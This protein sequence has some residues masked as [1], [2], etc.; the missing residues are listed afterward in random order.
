MFSRCGN[1]NKKPGPLEAEVI[2]VLHFRGGSKCFRWIRRSSKA[3][4]WAVRDLSDSRQIRGSSGCLAEHQFKPDASTIGINDQADQT[5]PL[6]P[7]FQV[8][9][10]EN[11][12]ENTVHTGE[13]PFSC[14]QCSKSFAQS[15]GLQ[16]HLRIHSGEKPYSCSQCS[17]SFAQ[18]NHL[19]QHFR[20]HSG[21]K[22]YSCSQCSMSAADL[23]SWLY[24]LIHDEF[25]P[26]EETRL[27]LHYINVCSHRYNVQSRLHI[28]LP[29]I[30]ILKF[31]L[32]RNHS[33]AHSAQSPF[34]LNQTWRNVL[35]FIL[36]RNLTAALNVHSHLPSH[37]GCKNI[38]EITRG[39]NL[40]AVKIVQSHLRDLIFW[41]VIL[42]QVFA[43]N[44]LIWLDIWTPDECPLCIENICNFPLS[45]P[46]MSH[47]PPP[48]LPRLLDLPLSFHSGK[49][50]A[51]IPLFPLM[52]GQI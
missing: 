39:R 8:I 10:P 45:F 17:K 1:D 18:S 12:I 22:P 3:G 30:D 27:H 20:V 29:Y 44:L 50:R 28:S 33:A 47:P 6:L 46:S 15:S 42:N 9:C 49:P 36:V 14:S 43:A 40:T 11:G 26:I 34:P 31:T 48:F 41:D 38:Y 25:P 32:E 2:P 19:H 23:L 24:R 16:A 35:E 51:R 21:E 5:P 7:V 4:G 37:L 13:K 52:S